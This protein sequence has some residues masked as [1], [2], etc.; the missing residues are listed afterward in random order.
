MM[1]AET[2]RACGETIFQALYPKTGR[3]A[4]IEAIPSSNG[5]VLLDEDAGT[6]RIVSGADLQAARDGGLSLHLNHFAGCP[7]AQRFHRS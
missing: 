6:Y 3:R 5:N 1:R 4:P 7:A 2:C